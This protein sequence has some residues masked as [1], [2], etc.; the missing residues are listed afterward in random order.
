MGRASLRESFVAALATDSWAEV[1]AVDDLDGL[2][3]RWVHE[4]DLAWPGLS[5]APT[6]FVVHLATRLPE[7]A[8]RDGADALDR[9]TDV[10]LA[11]GCCEGDPRALAY[12][13]AHFVP[14]IEK[15]WKTSRDRAT[16]LDDAKQLLR[17]KLLTAE[18]GD[19]P[20]IATY[21]GAGKLSTWVRVTAARLLAD[22][23]A[24]AAREE[25][26]D[27]AFFRA[28]VVEGDHPELELLKA[29]YRD[30]FR[31]AFSEAVQVLSFR[32]RN[33]LRYALVDGLTVDKVGDI[34][35]VSRSTAA[36]W[37]ASAREGLLAE[38]ERQL[39]SRLGLSAAEYQS[40]MRLI[41]SRVDVS[42]ERCLAKTCAG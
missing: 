13:D 34:Y 7:G 36:R 18:P 23:P 35:G 3:E 24:R 32:S 16:S 27:D 15:V 31:R 4:A 2:L 12:F 26:R 9:V 17:C 22:A 42:I 39:R 21:S 30:E 10:Y 37:L 41:A 1:N 8:L 5:V 38:L 29:T 14:V 28:L 11:F 40:V 19:R 6:A 20:R 25:Q 33:L